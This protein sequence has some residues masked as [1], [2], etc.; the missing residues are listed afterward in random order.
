MQITHEYNDERLEHVFKRFEKKAYKDHA[1]KMSHLIHDRLG[2]QHGQC[3]QGIQT[4]HALAMYRAHIRN[5][6]KDG[7]VSGEMSYDD[8]VKQLCIAL[9]FARN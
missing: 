1:H 9:D 5:K 7:M 3:V 2:L 8:F 6:T 4:G